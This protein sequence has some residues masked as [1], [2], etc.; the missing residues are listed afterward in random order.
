M[1]LLSV[2]MATG[3][4]P[5]WMGGATGLAL[6]LTY[7]GLQSAGETEAGKTM[8]EEWSNGQSLWVVQ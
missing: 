4:L 5:I 7:S 6:A 3:G 2:G 1:G 8:K